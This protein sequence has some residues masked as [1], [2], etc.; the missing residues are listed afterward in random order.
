MIDFMRS[1]SDYI[2]FAAVT[3]GAKPPWITRVFESV[4]TAALAGG[5]GAALTM[6][7]GIKVMERD[8]IYEKAR[9]DAHM[10]RYEAQVTKRDAELAR[11]RF[12]RTTGLAEI[13]RKLERI[14]DCIRTRTCTK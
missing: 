13:V 4:L 9:L 3:A 2:P 1:F 7:V 10:M 5:L 11:D 14:E 12:D 8:F 6:Y